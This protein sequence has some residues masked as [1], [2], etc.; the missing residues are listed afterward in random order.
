MS[1]SSAFTLRERIR[2][3]G[4]TYVGLDATNVARNDLN[5]VSI[6]V[7]RRWNLVEIA[8]FS[9]FRL[10]QYARNTVPVTWFKILD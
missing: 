1:S 4:N 3:M 5:K 10:T 9:G 2:I 8:S 7:S 6:R